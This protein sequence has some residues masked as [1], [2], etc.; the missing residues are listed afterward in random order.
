MNRVLGLALHPKRLEHDNVIL[1]S[2]LPYH[3]DP[4]LYG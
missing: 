3:A 4:L 2:I 1:P